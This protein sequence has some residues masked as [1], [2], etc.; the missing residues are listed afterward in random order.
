MVSRVFRVDVHKAD[1]S[2][3][4]AWSF[5]RS[6][7]VHSAGSV[8]WRNRRRARP[9]NVPTAIAMV[10]LLATVRTLVTKNRARLPPAAA[11]APAD[12]EPL[13]S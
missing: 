11:C 3:A 6:A 5:E 10:R 7:G 2:P 13:V 1:A 9:A 12:P 8:S 4:T